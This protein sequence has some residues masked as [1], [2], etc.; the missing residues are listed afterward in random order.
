MTEKQVLA[1]YRR[2]NKRFFDG[3][4][5]HD[6][7]IKYVEVPKNSF[8][9]L[10]TMVAVDGLV[11]QCIYL[12]KALRDRDSLIKFSLLHEMVHVKLHPTSTAVDAHG[13][14]FDDEMMRLA[15]RGAFHNLW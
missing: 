14:E 13:K 3:K 2:Y 12:D 7:P 4:L 8:C 5:P 1:C 11:L 15:F 10:T 6:I 9:G